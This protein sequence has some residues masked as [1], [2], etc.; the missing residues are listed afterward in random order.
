MTFFKILDFLTFLS[1]V[2]LL[3]GIL[4]G[5]YYYKFLDTV[6]KI[7]TLYLIVCLCTDVVSRIYGH[8]YQNNLIF[9]LLFSLTEVGIFS[10]LYHTCFLE[11]KNR[12]LLV[13]TT[14]ASLYI[15]WEID[16]LRTIQV[17]QFQS[18]S[19]VADSFLIILLAIVY[20]FEKIGKNVQAELGILRLN[21][22][23]L[24]YF[25]LSLVFFLPINFL[26]NVTSDLK[27]YFWGANLM[28]TLTFYGFISCEIW[29]N[30]LNLKQSHSGSQ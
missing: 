1:P 17:Q 11:K 9:I 18:Y 26:I 20:F 30:G 12:L 21:S 10:V 6:Y 19:K 27:F 29:K 13:L 28:L 7:L 24:I 8:F 22:V 4:I 5:I 16:T 23:I 15:L 2:L 14:I 25:A 3:C